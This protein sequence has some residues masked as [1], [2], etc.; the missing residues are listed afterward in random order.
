MPK[1]KYSRQK[2]SAIK[3]LKTI[4]KDGV[5]KNLIDQSTMLFRNTNQQAIKTRRTYF[6]KYN[7]FL[8]Y[9]ASVSKVKSLK[10]INGKYIYG[11]VETLK[12]RGCGNSHIQSALSAIRFFHNLTD[13]KN[14]L[15]QNEV[16]QEK[17]CI[18]LEKSTRAKSKAWTKEET[19][20][21]LEICK[22]QN[23]PDV[24]L[25]INLSQTHGLRL[26]E[27][28]NLTKLQVKKALNTGKLNIQGKGGKI[29]DIPVVSETQKNVLSKLLDFA[30][31]STIY[32]FKENRDGTVKKTVSYK[33]SIQDFIYNNREKAQDPNRISSREAQRIVL[34]KKNKSERVVTK[35][36]QGI[37]VDL[38][39]HGCR[40]T[41]AQNRYREILIEERAKE[42]VREREL[43]K[44]E[45]GRIN[46]KQREREIRESAARRVS[47]EMGHE[48]TEVNDIYQK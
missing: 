24:K 41:Y 1:T 36:G 7:K 25:M 15:P 19:E 38:T 37:K 20:K 27:M 5:Y 26:E 40:H 12:E 33:K 6:Q 30:K 11:Y 23:R 29:R 48:R 18:N 9:V 28:T 22:E 47:R 14:L 42:R 16:I 43:P 3:N 2:N 13:S 35:N 8:E 39:I 34:D 31:D 32:I 46:K 44:H 10:N 17:T 4:E 21:F 45:R